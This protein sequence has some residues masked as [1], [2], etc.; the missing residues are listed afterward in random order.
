MYTY[1]Y[2]HTYIHI[3]IGGEGGGLFAG[4]AGGRG[5]TGR[6]AGGA[7]QT[8]PVLLP[9]AHGDWWIVASDE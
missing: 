2:V 3:Y 4:G 8:Q 1:L 7:A 9:A 5:G 6:N